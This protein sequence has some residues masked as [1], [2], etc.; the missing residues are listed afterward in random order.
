MEVEEV[1]KEL[2][3]TLGFSACHAE[4]MIVCSTCF[5]DFILLVV[6]FV[7][8]AS[9]RIKSRSR[10]SLMGISYCVVSF[11]TVI[12]SIRIMNYRAH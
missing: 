12:A 11:K 7:E 6:L 2:M 10:N 1:E 9:G 8:Y 5:T 3:S 4:L